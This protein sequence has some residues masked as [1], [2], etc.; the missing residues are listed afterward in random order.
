MSDKQRI[1]EDLEDLKYLLQKPKNIEIARI[2][3]DSM[4][5]YLT[6]SQQ[7]DTPPYEFNQ[8]PLTLAEQKELQEWNEHFRVAHNLHISD[9]QTARARLL[10]ERMTKWGIITK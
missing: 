3:I 10:E 7:V 9:K 5:S 1:I 6:T 2:M 4:M 8:D